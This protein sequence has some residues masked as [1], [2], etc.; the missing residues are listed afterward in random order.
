MLLKTSSTAI[1]T[2]L[3]A[4]A[5][6]CLTGCGPAGVNGPVD[7]PA[8]TTAEGATTINGSVTVG[9]GA[10]VGETATV[11]GGVH[12]GANVTANSART[13]NGGIEVGNGTQIVHDIDAVN[14]TIRLGKGTDVGGSVKNINGGI[15]I[16]AAHVTNGIST[17]TGDIELGHGSHVE[18]GIHVQKPDFGNDMNRTPRIVIGAESVVDGTLK[19]DREVKLLVSDTAKIGP[20][21]GATVQLFAG[22]DP[23]HLIEPAEAIAE[24]AEVP[25]DKPADKPAGGAGAA[26][27]KP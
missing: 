15:R 13:V 24:T 14:G 20:V 8:G 23:T 16:D 17:F 6:T 3:A 25:G 18:G 19:F 21:E 10:K 11:N 2:F 7:V 4:V 9:D 27:Q 1:L 5:A 22:D 26:A 12:L